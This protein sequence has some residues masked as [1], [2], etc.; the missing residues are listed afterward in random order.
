MNVNSFRKV[1]SFE[2]MYTVRAS[3]T[4]SSTWS[5]WR[6][7]RPRSAYALRSPNFGQKHISNF[8]LKGFS[9]WM[10]VDVPCQYFFSF[11]SDTVEKN[12]YS[13]L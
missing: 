6:R 9:R 10:G 13:V 12:R 11:F 3:N 1:V 8:R 5:K 4:K 2:S 7:R